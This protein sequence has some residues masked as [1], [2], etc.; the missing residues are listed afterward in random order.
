MTMATGHVLEVICFYSFLHS[1]L[2]LSGEEVEETEIAG[3]ATD[4]E[5]F[6]CSN[7]TGERI[8]QVTFCGGL[9]KLLRKISIAV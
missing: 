6:Y 1:A 2:S 7:I 9:A 5:T 8:I 3:L 4:Q